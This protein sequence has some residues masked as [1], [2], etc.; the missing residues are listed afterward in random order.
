M[1]GGVVGDVHDWRCAQLGVAGAVH[2]CNWLLGDD[3]GSARL[4]DGQGRQAE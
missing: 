3:E 2:Y 4:P 1:W